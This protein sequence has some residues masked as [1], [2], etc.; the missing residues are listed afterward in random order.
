M[1]ATTIP[2][3]QYSSRQYVPE[4]GDSAFQ[5]EVTICSV[6]RCGASRDI[7]RR[8]RQ[9]VRTFQKQR[10]RGRRLNCPGSSRL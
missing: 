2:L 3:V 7:R 4:R 1:R 8:L 10:I 9:R 6:P 5:T